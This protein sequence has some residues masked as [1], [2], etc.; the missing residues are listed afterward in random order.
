M[1]VRSMKIHEEKKTTQRLF[2]MVQ[3]LQILVY[4]SDYLIHLKARW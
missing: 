3:K 2:K 4:G 1:L